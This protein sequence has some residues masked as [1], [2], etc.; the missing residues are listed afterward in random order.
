MKDVEIFT[1]P[2]CAHCG[3]AKALLRAHDIAF[4]EHDI[5]EPEAM[6]DL[7]ARLPRVRAIP[8]VFVAGMHLGNDEDLRLA[9]RP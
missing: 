2:G 5:S 8:Q 7:Q 3:A 6:A 4:V 1:G 9:L